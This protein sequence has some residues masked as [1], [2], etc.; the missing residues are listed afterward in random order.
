MKKLT[1]KSIH[2]RNTS[3]QE[4]MSKGILCYYFAKSVVDSLA[5]KESVNVNYFADGV[6]SCQCR[7]TLKLGSS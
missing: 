6:A 7:K 2:S 3:L 5:H 1:S 4:K